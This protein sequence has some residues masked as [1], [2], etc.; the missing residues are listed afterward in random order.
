VAWN[1][2]KK[3]SNAF[4][5][6]LENAAKR[7]GVKLTQMAE[8]E[9]VLMMDDGQSSRVSLYSLRLRTKDL[10]E[11]ELPIVL[12]RFVDAVKNGVRE[13]RRARLVLDR[14]RPVLLP[15]VAFPGLRAD[16]DDEPTHGELFPGFVSTYLV[17]D[18]PTGAWY[19]QDH[20]LSDWNVTFDELLPVAV[21]NLGQRTDKAK[22]HPLAAS[23]APGVYEYDSGDSFDAARLLV[24]EHLLGPLPDHGV[25]VMVPSQETLLCVP[26]HAMEAIAAMNAML[27]LG[28]AMCSKAKSGIT[29]QPFW[30]DGRAW[31]HVPVQHRRGAVEVKP[32][33]RFVRALEHLAKTGVKRLPGS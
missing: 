5:R 13:D 21:E 17:A 26:L 30:F 4:A 11:K 15:R 14:I 23:P 29:D 7:A 2:F 28:K 19:L 22:L 1:L 27:I 33:D 24:L 16:D 8:D 18:E 31:Q 3:K 25:V 20:H 10:S 9:A 6:Q 32:P 12:E